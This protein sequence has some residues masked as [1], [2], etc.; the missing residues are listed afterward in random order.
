MGISFQERYSSEETWHGKVLVMEIYHLAMS[1]LYKN[2]TISK[3][4]E[5]FNCS[6]GLASENLRLANAIHTHQDIVKCKFRE[7]ALTNLRKG[8]YATNLETKRY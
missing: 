6:V 7:Q 4:A 5:Q 1:Q 3:T 8:K 2:W